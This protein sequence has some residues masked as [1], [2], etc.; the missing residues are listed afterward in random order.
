VLQYSIKKYFLSLFITAYC[1]IK[2]D[3]GSAICQGRQKK[4]H[5]LAAELLGK[6]LRYHGMP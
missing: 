1:N 5:L 3:A 2:Q 4:D 6:Q